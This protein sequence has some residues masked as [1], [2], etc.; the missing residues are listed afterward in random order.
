MTKWTS[1]RP[2][3]LHLTMQCLGEAILQQR[4]EHKDWILTLNG[5]QIATIPCDYEPRETAKALIRGRIRRELT[6]L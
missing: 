4:I 3:Q 5:V 1:D 2:G 6:E